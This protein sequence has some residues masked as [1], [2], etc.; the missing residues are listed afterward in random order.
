MNKVRALRRFYLDLANLIDQTKVMLKTCRP[1]LVGTRKQRRFQAKNRR[2]DAQQDESR[3]AKK[4]F[5]VVAEHYVH[6]SL[7]LRW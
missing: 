1:F 7:G 5:R 2:D 6:A 4:A 3:A